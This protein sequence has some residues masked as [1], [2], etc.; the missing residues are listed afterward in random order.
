MARS[1][2]CSALVKLL[3]D[4]S[5]L[6]ASHSSWFVFQAMERIYKHYNFQRA[7]SNLG[8]FNLNFFAKGRVLECEYGRCE[9][10]RQAHCFQRAATSL[11]MRFL[12]QE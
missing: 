7:A 6:Y 11:G 3:G 8:T 4:F 2:R 5:D 12:R 1:G 10:H 9:A